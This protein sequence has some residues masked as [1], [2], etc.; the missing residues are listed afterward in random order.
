MGRD[1][2]RTYA[3]VFEVHRL[4]EPVSFAKDVYETG[5]WRELL[6]FMIWE[7]LHKLCLFPKSSYLCFSNREPLKL[8]DADVS[9]PSSL[10]KSFSPKLDSMGLQIQP[11]KH[12]W[13][14]VWTRDNGTLIGSLYPDSTELYETDETHSMR[15]LHSFAERIKSIFVSSSG[16][17]FVCVKGAVYRWAANETSF[18]MVL[19]LA[20]SESYF[21]HNNGMTETA[22]GGLIIGEYGNVWQR[23]R[24]KKMPY[25]YSS[26]DD[27]MTWASSDVLLKKGANKHVHV[28]KYSRLLNKLLVTDGDNYKKLWISTG[29]ELCGGNDGAWTPSNRFHIQMGGYTSIVETQGKLFFGSDY[30]GGTNFIVDSGDG[31]RFRKKIVPDPYRR[32]PVDNMVL[33]RSPEGTEIWANLPYSAGASRCLLMVS[34]DA[35]KTWTRL[36]DYSRSTHLVWLTNSSNRQTPD[37]YIS[38]ENSGIQSRTAYRIGDLQ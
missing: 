16:T 5:K 34:R 12:N 1:L 10:T 19:R 38:I 4:S 20:S 26:C 33:R 36:L 7:I 17:V 22:D 9:N 18:E 23:G 32:S 30:Q 8:E 27:G 21:R 3:S 29:A 6:S 2:T 14:V 31:K 25:L 24:W 35:G 28:V 37:L 15:L 11:C 13:R